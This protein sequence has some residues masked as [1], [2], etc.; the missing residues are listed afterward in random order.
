MNA[1]HTGSTGRR[2]GKIKG[3]KRGKEKTFETKES[4]RGVVFKWKPSFFT[5]D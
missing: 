1:S 4:Q 5:G 3:Q 2:E